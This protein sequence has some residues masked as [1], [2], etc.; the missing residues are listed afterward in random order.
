MLYMFALG[1][2]FKIFNEEKVPGILNIY[3]SI[4][5]YKR[6]AYYFLVF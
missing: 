3:K 1:Y 4:R 2:L 6:V 5:I